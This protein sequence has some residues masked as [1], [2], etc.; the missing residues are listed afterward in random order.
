MSNLKNTTKVKIDDYIY[1]DIRP[2]IDGGIVAN[3]NDGEIVMTI[4]DV[5]NL[6]EWLIIS[7]ETFTNISILSARR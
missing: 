3:I 2:T 4:D 6:L 5:R 1:A 7:T